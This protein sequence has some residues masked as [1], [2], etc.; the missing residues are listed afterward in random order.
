MRVGG[1]FFYDPTPSS[2][3]RD[4][5]LI[6][7]GVGINPLFSILRHACNLHAADGNRGPNKLILLYSAATEEELVF[8][9]SY[10]FIDILLWN[11]HPHVPVFFMSTPA[12]WGLTYCCIAVMLSACFFV[13][14][15]IVV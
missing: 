1:D 14:Q 11:T 8:K 7:G 10:P 13:P 4:L 2:A 9:V 3:P 5:L 15:V 6:A 12:G